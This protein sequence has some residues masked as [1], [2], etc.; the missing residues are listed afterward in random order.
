VETASPSLRVRGT[1]AL[2]GRATCLAR[3][4]AAGHVAAGDDRGEVGLWAADGERL[5]RF[6]LASAA[7]CV[8]IDPEGRR[9]VAA[10][11]GGE[12]LFLAA[13]GKQPLR[14]AAR[15]GVVA[16]VDGAGEGFLLVDPRTGEGEVRDRTGAL[17]RKFAVPGPCSGIAAVPRAHGVLAAKADGVLARVADGGRLA[18]GGDFGRPT[19]G[20]CCDPRGR[21]AAIALVARGVE[22]RSMTTGAA[23]RTIDVAHPVTCVADAGDRIAL[24]CADGVVAVVTPHGDLVAEARVGTR[25]LGVGLCAADRTVFALLA[26]GTVRALGAESG[27]EATDASGA[28]GPTLRHPIDAAAERA[29]GVRLV[30]APDGS[31]VA[32]SVGGA[33]VVVARREGGDPVRVVVEGH[34]LDL[35]F[36]PDG[37]LVVATTREVRLVRT[38][39][40]ARLRAFAPEVRTASFGPGGAVLAY[41][42]EVGDVRLE[43]AETGRILV[44]ARLCAAEG[45]VALFA[46]PAALA[47]RTLRQELRTFGGGLERRIRLEGASMPATGTRDGPVVARGPE[48]ESFDWSGRSR[49]IHRMRGDAAT[50]SPVAD[51]AVVAAREGEA[52]VVARDGVVP[53]STSL[54]PGDL[55]DAVL[56]R[57]GAPVLLLRDGRRLV[58][59]G[60]A[61]RAAATVILERRP[62]V[63]RLLPGG[64]LAAV[65]PG[66]LVVLPTAAERDTPGPS[67]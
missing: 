57:A 59:V 12:V 66:A 47:V 58:A 44:R 4:A 41:F 65:V 56:P 39:G 61:G 54:P 8:D 16:L 27:P 49:W 24:G 42:D 5:A 30:V 51:G 9:L 34:V 63:A 64:G 45:A 29:S 18:W 1:L 37:D 35:A 15:R 21:R 53:V 52:I 22:L 10:S 20:V 31:R 28:P 7:V 2:P 14:C 48:V 55:A 6:R 13:A 43:A 38:D 36:R 50:L 26:D 32:A 67:C 33:E 25:V 62:I 11:A 60:R 46:A 19:A 17:V 3:A 23:L 40:D